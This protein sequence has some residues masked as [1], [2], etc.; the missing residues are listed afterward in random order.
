MQDSISWMAA[1]VAGILSFLSPCVLPIFPAYLSYLIADTETK[2]KNVILF[3]AFGFILGFSLVFIAL[4]GSA[5]L[6][7][8]FLN[9]NKVFLRELSGVVMIFFGLHM[10]GILRLKWLYQEKRILYNPKKNTAS[11]GRSVL[12]GFIFAAGW[13]PC[14]G[15][16]LASILVYAGSTQT[17]TQGISLLTL[18]S[19]GLALPFLAFALFAERYGSKF[20]KINHLLPYFTK[21]SG[22]LMIILGY[23]VFYNK[24]ALLNSVF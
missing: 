1:F 22:V 4:G 17:L 6:L 9:V 20:K 3:R 5:S 14:I 10:V 13:T 23:L 21:A 7:G 24:L 11:F 8:K 2:S 15:P 18:Y 16:I 12:L 19:L